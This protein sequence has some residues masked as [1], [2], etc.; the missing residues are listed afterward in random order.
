MARA[1]IDIAMI[2]LLKT[3][4][5]SVVKLMILPRCIL[6][7]T[8]ETMIHITARPMKNGVCDGRYHLRL[9]GLVHIIARK[10]IV[11]ITI[12][13]IRVIVLNLR[14]SIYSNPADAS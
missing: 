12:S 6:P 9:A 10:D 3:L 4:T 2:L 8:S 5:K 14:F 11:S 7:L 13:A 1:V